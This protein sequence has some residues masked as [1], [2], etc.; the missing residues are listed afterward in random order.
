MLYFVEVE[1]E[2]GSVLNVI[3]CEPFV[4]PLFPNPLSQSWLALF[5]RGPPTRRLFLL[6]D[7]IHSRT[8]HH[9]SPSGSALRNL[10]C[11][12]ST[13]CTSKF[14]ETASNQAV[15]Y[16]GFVSRERHDCLRNLEVWHLCCCSSG[17]SKMIHSRRRTQFTSAL[18]SSCN[19]E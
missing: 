12:L 8:F 13:D 16:T 1:S 5:V 3:G 9:P 4:V 14:S 11:L 2:C 17:T 15:R 19:V 10:Y 18:F 6:T 7:K